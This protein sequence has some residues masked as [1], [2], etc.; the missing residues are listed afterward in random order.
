MEH[1]YS[2]VG[3][4]EIFSFPPRFKSY[5]T[6]KLHSVLILFSFL[7]IYACDNLSGLQK[8]QRSELHGRSPPHYLTT[9]I[10]LLGRLATGGIGGLGLGGLPNSFF[11]NCLLYLLL[12]LISWSVDSHPVGGRLST[13]RI[14][15]MQELCVSVNQVIGWNHRHHPGNPPNFSP[16]AQPKKIFYC[17]VKEDC[18][19]EGGESSIVET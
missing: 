3:E 6:R 10:P 8:T 12:L 1:P 14:A 18:R 2:P 16:Q 15:S 9:G 17:S 19:L 5:Q 11:P 13:T 7:L 4:N